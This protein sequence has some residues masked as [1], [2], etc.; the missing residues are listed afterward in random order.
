MGSNPV[1]FEG[2]AWDWPRFESRR[3]A[4]RPAIPPELPSEYVGYN[5]LKVFG[6]PQAKATL[7]AGPYLCNHGHDIHRSTGWPP[8]APAVNTRRSKSVILYIVMKLLILSLLAISAYAE[9]RPALKP[10]ESTPNTRT[11]IYKTTPQGELKVDIFL[12]EGWAPGQKHPA[13][14][15]FFGGGF[16]NGTPL[17]FRTKGEYLASRG[18]VALTPDYRVKSRHQTSPRESIEDAKS[19]IRW[20]RLN[21]NALGIDPD[22]IV[23]SGGSAGG[24]SAA[25]T[26]LSASYEPADEDVSISSK[27]NALV[28]YNPALLVPQTGTPA[29]PQDEVLTAWKIGKNLPPM[30][31][32]FGTEDN[33][34]AGSRAVA[35]QAVEAGNRAVIYTAAG[36]KHGFFN[37]TSTSKN[38]SPGWHE[39]VLY[40]TDLFLASLG[41]LIG[42]PTVMP[43]SSLS[44]VRDPP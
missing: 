36:Q 7:A 20:A 33:L 10:V 30:I 6:Q 2:P 37:D 25:L 15:M 42:P 34:L 5:A 21:A 31:F 28:L 17:Q 3:M 26:A 38:G 27:P 18:M 1:V 24:T 8:Q 19:A 23:A 39:V 41:Y 13:I 43:S 29:T 9:L 14:L 22:R 32:F 11:Y 12:P 16:T 40:R 35:K 44:L 4:F